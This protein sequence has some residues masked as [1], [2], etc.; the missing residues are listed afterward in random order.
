MCYLPIDSEEGIAYFDEMKYCVEFAL[1]NR[2][3]ILNNIKK[4]LLEIY[5]SVRFDKTI[6][7]AHNYAS[8]ETHFGEDV[9][10][11]R[12]GATSAK[13]GEFGIIPV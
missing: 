4:A 12:K 6:N 5:P 13:S 1:S 11:H 10:V 7:I 2:T 3:L 8:F 9:I